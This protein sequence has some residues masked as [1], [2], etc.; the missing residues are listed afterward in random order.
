MQRYCD[1]HV[2]RFLDMEAREEHGEE[3][4]EEEEDQL[5]GSLMH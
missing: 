4:E 5:E 1:K 3:E 2:S